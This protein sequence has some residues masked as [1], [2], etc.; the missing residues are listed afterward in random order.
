[1]NSPGSV[2][3]F[4]Y[5]NKLPHLK[6]FKKSNPEIDIHVINNENN[7]NPGYSW[8]SPDKRLRKWW[9][10]NSNKVKGEII[11]VMEYDVL[12][13]KSLPM[14]SNNIDLAGKYIRNYNNTHKWNWFDPTEIK[15]LGNLIPFG[16]VPF[17]F[18]LV[19]RKCLE[20]ICE[21]KWNEYFEKDIFCEIRIPSI[22]Y[23]NDFKI[24]TI[25]IPDINIGDPIIPKKE[26]G[27]YHP[28]KNAIR[29]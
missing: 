20:F 13:T 23:N 26:P 14:L 27:I 12:V 2:L 21:E 4:T 29:F 15:E 18:F 24:G 5:K 10:E 16:I 28:V 17:C 6:Y 25:D 7:E 8:R 9:K 11:C 22:L 19:R 1:M 3:V